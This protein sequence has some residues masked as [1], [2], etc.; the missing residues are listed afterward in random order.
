M[1][2]SHLREISDSHKCKGKIT[3]KKATLNFYPNY[4]AHKKMNKEKYLLEST[5]KVHFNFK[6]TLLKINRLQS[7]QEIS[8][9]KNK[10]AILN[11]KKL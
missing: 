5:R 4:S 8:H 7:I 11:N 9:T 10:K 6:V 3:D 1:S 2:R